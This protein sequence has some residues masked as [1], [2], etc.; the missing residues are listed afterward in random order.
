MDVLLPVRPAPTLAELLRR[1]DF[2]RARPDIV[3]ELLDRC[4]D[5]L[6]E[7]RPDKERSSE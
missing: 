6:M 7:D 1:S 3:D 4:A 2:A 5:P